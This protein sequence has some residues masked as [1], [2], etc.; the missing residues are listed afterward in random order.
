[1]KEKSIRDITLATMRDEL[2]QFPKN[3]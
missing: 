1:M 3:S 2:L